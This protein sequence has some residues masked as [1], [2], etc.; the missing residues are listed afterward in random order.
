MKAL[1]EAA[2]TTPSLSLEFQMLPREVF[3]TKES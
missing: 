1:E 2:R 3:T